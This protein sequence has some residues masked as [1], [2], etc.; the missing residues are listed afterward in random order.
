MSDL[1][2]P[3]T[4]ENVDPQILQPSPEFKQEAIKVL[5]AIFFFVV[6]YI[7]LVIAALGLALLCAAGGIGLI[8]LK[9]MIITLMLGVGLAGLGI[10]VVI[11]LFKF[12]FKRHKVDR[13][14]LIEIK[15]QEHP[16]LFEFIRTLAKETQTSFPKKIYLSPEVNAS[17]FYD[18]S[19]WSMFLPVKKNL[20]IG[21]G[22]V[23]AVNV[24]EFKAIIAHEFGHFSQ[25]SMKLGSYVYNMNHII[26]N[27]LYDNDNY[28]R[29]IQRWANAS[30]YFTFF[31]ALTMYIVR[32]VQWVL[33][34][35]Y[36]LVN[37]IYL[38]LSRQ[39]EFHAD[40]VAAS[41]SGGNHLIA[42]LRRLEVADIT[43]NNVFGFYQDNFRKGLK[44]ENVYPQHTQLMHLFSEFH[45][46]PYEHG[47]PQVDA[48][49]FA[50]FN[51]ERVMVKDQWASHP[52][53]DDRENHLR[54][55]HIETVPQHTTAWQLFNN[56]EALQQQV[57]RKIFDEVKYEAP[58]ELINE[59]SFRTQY[60]ESMQ[61]YQLPVIYKGFFDSRYITKVDLRN[62]ESRLATDVD[63][64]PELLTE[65]VLALPYQKNGLTRD[66]QTLE[67]ITNGNL[68][69]KNFEFDGQRFKAN[70]AAALHTQL[71]NELSETERLLTEADHK[72]MAWF[73]RKAEAS[74][75]RET[76]R[77]KYS[78]L[79][80]QSEAVDSDINVYNAMQECLMPLYQ[81]M[82]IPEI[83]KAIAKLKEQEAIFRKRLEQMLDDPANA[84][85]ITEEQRKTATEYLSKEWAYFQAQTYIQ[86]D[87]ERLHECLYLF[88]NVPNEKAFR[89]KADVL[90][91]QLE[92]AGLK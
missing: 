86:S 27:M 3:L 24:S 85:F 75:N 10:M 90:N 16:R 4:P 80:I 82:Q 79:F 63:T 66:L 47:L 29:A 8:V 7:V 73:L 51:K 15:E 35:V 91:L 26:F 72:L 48:K 23:N 25:R 65:T 78:N 22:L 36:T 18:S 52:S 32:G 31:A 83:E 64:L 57:T 38:S 34:Q 61:R 84:E 41:V 89:A 59:N 77:E 13:S 62:L 74:G 87:L 42:S 19:F 33:Q 21:L 12:L 20:M 69:V 76:L 9:P 55:L 37:K 14:G 54:T 70:Q 49:S 46:L 40:A 11:F 67:A 81:V 50:N 56:A 43:Y 30:S 71:Q 6:V 5:G 53:T 17:V 28:E 1:S 88:V 68:R 58:I 60:Q 44:P 2:Y 45:G 39:M 92:F